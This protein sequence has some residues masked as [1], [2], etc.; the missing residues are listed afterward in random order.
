MTKILKITGIWNFKARGS[1]RNAESVCWAMDSKMRENQC[2]S[3]G[4][5]YQAKSHTKLHREA[6]FGG[7]ERCLCGVRRNNCC[8]FRSCS[9]EKQQQN[10]LMTTYIFFCVLFLKHSCLLEK[11]FPDSHQALMTCG[12]FLTFPTARGVFTQ[13]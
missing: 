3:S 11:Q 9:S 2:L 12:D 4:T 6:S 5:G 13:A 10:D 1:Q 8:I 7:A